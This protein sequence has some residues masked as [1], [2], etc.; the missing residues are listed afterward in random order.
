MSGERTM[1]TTSTPGMAAQHAIITPD[2][3]ENRTDDGA[4]D[5]AVARAKAAYDGIVRGWRHA[6]EQ[7]TLHLVLTVERPQDNGSGSETR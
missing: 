7:P 5:E 2:C 3:R 4:W 6:A 1:P